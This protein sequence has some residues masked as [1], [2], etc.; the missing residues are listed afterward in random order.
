MKKKTKKRKKEC[1]CRVTYE[2]QV[3]PALDRLLD[4]VPVKY[5]NKLKVFVACVCVRAVAALCALGIY[6]NREQ[7]NAAITHTRDVAPSGEKRAKW[8]A[9][10]PALF[11]EVPRD[12]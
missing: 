5:G 8:P 1:L 11:D 7:R 3:L 10:S 4:N 6:I 9:E 2:K 12:R